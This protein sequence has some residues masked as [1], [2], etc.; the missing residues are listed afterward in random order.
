[1]RQS[2]TFQWVVAHRMTIA[3]ILSMALILSGAAVSWVALNLTE[4]L[5]DFAITVIATSILACIAIE[6]GRRRYWG[7]HW[8][9]YALAARSSLAASDSPSDTRHPS[10]PSWR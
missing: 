10:S 5:K 2:Q 8:G 6:L 9:W 3:E 1:M 7:L 4:H